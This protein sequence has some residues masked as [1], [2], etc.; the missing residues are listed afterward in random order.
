MIDLPYRPCVGAALFNVHGKVLVAR[1]ADLANAEGRPG[2]W[3]LPQG[4]ID[5]GEDPA[6]GPQLL[7]GDAA[8]GD[9]RCDL[10]LDEPP[11]RPGGH[12]RHDAVDDAADDR[13]SEP[14][15][16]PLDAACDDGQALSQG[17]GRQVVHV[18]GSRWVE[19]QVRRRVRRQSGI[20]VVGTR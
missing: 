15:G 4:G 1:R 12:D 17:R 16:L 3:Q 14:P 8:G 9:G 18:W 19:R 11:D 13:E 7:G 20:R 6:D 5:E 2:G 10:V